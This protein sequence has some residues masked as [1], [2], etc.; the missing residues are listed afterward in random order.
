[1]DQKKK[2]LYWIKN[3]KETLNPVNDEAKY[4]Q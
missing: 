4:F 1:M 3:K 2:K